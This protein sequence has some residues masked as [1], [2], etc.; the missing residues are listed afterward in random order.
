[1]DQ[2]L[3]RLTEAYLQQVIPLAEYQRRRQDLGQRRQ[4]LDNQTEQLRTQVE[5]QRELAGLVEHVEDFCHRI[6]HGLSTATFEQKRQLVEL[7]V[8]RVI[9]TEA[10]VEIRYVIPTSHNGEHAR[11]CHLRSDYFGNQGMARVV[12]EVII[13]AGRV[14]ASE[15]FGAD[16]LPAAARAASGT[17]GWGQQAGVFSIMMALAGKLF[18]AAEGTIGAGFGL[19]RARGFGLGC[20]WNW[21]PPAGETKHEPD[22]AKQQNQ[23]E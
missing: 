14:M 11:F 22:E 4:T 23:C 7:L 3:N 12:G 20:L 2:Q 19:E 1:L 18:G 17:P 21:V 10:D 16:G 5:C 6:Q 9:V 8:D 13:G 15:A